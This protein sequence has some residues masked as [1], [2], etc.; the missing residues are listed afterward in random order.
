MSAQVIRG[1]VCH[2]CEKRFLAVRGSALCP[3]CKE[4]SPPRGR[5]ATPATDLET[6]VARLEMHVRNIMQT[7]RYQD[8]A[9]TTLYEH[10]PS[11]KLARKIAEK[12]AEYKP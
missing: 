9:L 3:V 10:E 8:E 6:R 2:G 11:A 1:W 5:K 7:D 12:K 4:K